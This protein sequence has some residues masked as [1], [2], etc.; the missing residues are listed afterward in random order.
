MEVVVWC[1]K[2]KWRIG[3]EVV[4]NGEWIYRNDGIKFVVRYWG[5][6]L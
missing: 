6:F 2:E 1:D 5:E 4:L 3:R